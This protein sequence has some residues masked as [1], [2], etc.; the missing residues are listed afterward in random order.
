M[1]LRAQD[2]SGP[3]L[4]KLLTASEHE[5]NFVDRKGKIHNRILQTR[6]LTKYGKRYKKKGVL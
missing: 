2:I 1:G 5:V 6:H 3:R 4:A